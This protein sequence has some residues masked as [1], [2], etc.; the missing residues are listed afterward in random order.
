MT[1]CAIFANMIPLYIITIAQHLEQHVRRPA[2]LN[3]PSKLTK[4][5]SLYHSIIDF[6][7]LSVLE[8]QR[9]SILARTLVTELNPLQKRTVSRHKRRNELHRG[10]RKLSKIKFKYE[11][12]SYSCVKELP[13][14]Y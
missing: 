7:A 10:V 12:H 8:I 6:T 14:F 4:V 3:A 1:V 11:T 9:A 5:S 13:T 2:R